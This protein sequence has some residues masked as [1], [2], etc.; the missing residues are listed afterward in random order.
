MNKEQAAKLIVLAQAFVEGKQLECRR[1]GTNNPWYTTSN[2]TFD[3]H[4][5]D[6]RIKPEPRTFYALEWTGNA[7]QL[8]CTN[9]TRE[10]AERYRKL[11]SNPDAINIVELVEKL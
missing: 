1:H 3:L 6:Y 4:T 9:T 11:S 2:P 10:E 8:F 5:Y 7:G